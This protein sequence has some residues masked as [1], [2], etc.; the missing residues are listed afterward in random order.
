MN[1]E[2]ANRLVNLRKKHQL[3]QEELAN[4]LGI[5]R[6]AV[7]K[8]ERA[9]ASPDTDNLIRLAKL[10]N[11]SLDELLATEDEDLYEDSIELLKE[12]E[13]N[14][15]ETKEEEDDDS[16]V[17]IINRHHAKWNNLPYPIIVTIIY[18]LL[19]SFGGYW[20][21]AWVIFVTI[22]LYYSLIHAIK[23]RNIFAINYPVFVLVIYLFLGFVLDIW[24]GTWILFL[25]IPVFYGIGSM[26]RK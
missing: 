14:E 24:R 9:E 18:F 21:E 8:W 1:I 5:S 11:V 26:I 23:R 22:P 12:E 4:K 19:G 16:K 2:I 20:G 13:L 15:E 17:I 6:Q 10:Y 25:T 3:S 7:S